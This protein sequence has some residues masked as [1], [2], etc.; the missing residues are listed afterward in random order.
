V[1][2]SPSAADVTALTSFVA[3]GGRLIFMNKIPAA[4][5]A[6]AGV[7]ASTVDTSGARSVLQLTNTETPVQAL[8]GFDFTEY[9]DTNMPF[10]ENYTKS[11]LI[12]VGYTPIDGSQ[13]LGKYLVRNDN[14]VDNTDTSATSAAIVKYQPSG[15]SGYVYSFGMDLGYLFIQAQNEGG[16]YSP[17]YIGHYYPGYDIGTRII[18]NIVTTSPH[19]V[20]LWT[21]PYNKGLVFTTTWDIDTYVSYPHG[22]GMAAAAQDRG[23]AG[24]LNLHTKYI[25][26]AYENA[27]FQYG[28]P[29]IYQITGFRVAPDGHPFI[30]FGSHTVSHSPNAAEFSYGTL[31]EQYIQGSTAG[32]A[33]SIHQ[34]GSNPDGQPTGGSACVKGGPR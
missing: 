20:S 1:S 31:S 34:C 14:G 29:Y 13:T 23:A 27:Y 5:Q 26:D 3:R 30:D 32:Y 9:F 21:V 10:Y 28:V 16:G 25:T 18:K 4:L 6:L 8:Q 11:G 19:F 24:N 17:W 15:A 22:Q 33:P 2:Y 7:S 12:N